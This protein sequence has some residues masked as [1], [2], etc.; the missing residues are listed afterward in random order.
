[1]TTVRYYSPPRDT[2]TDGAQNCGADDNGDESRDK[3][4]KPVQGDS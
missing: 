3:N 4:R 1:M 2:K